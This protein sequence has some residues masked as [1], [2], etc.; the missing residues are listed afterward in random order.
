M[1]R[2]VAVLLAVLSAVVAPQVLAD[3]DLPSVTEGSLLYRSAVSGRYEP[4]PLQ[5]TD[6]SIDVR[7]L[8]ASATVSQVYV[9]RTDTP[10]E[11]VYVFPLPHEAAVYE[12]EMR[13]GD[14]LI[15]SVVKEREQARQTY[16][17]ARS[18]GK[19]AALVEQERPNVFTTSLANLMPGDRVEVRL[20]YVEPLAWQDGRVRLV[21]PMVVGPRYIPGQALDRPDTG[22]GWAP[23]TTQVADASRITPPLRNP[24]G[25]LG[26]ES[27]SDGSPQGARDGIHSRRATPEV[28]PGHDIA[29]RVRA[30]LGAPLAAVTSP[31]HEIEWTAEQGA[32]VVTLAR[33][34]TLPN[35]DFVLELKRE[36][37]S[38]PQ[39]ALFL[40]PDARG[41]ETHFMLV[42]YPPSPESLA[43]RPPLELVFLI[44]V[45][46]S[47][48]GT[49]IEQ[50]RAALLQGLDRLRPDDHFNIVAYDHQYRWFAPAA[51]QA[52]AEGLEQGRQFVRGLQAEG[53]TELLPALRHV[54]DT[55]V[56]PGLTRYIV[57]L[58][59]GCLGNEDE[60]FGALERGLRQSRL[61]TVAIG[62]APNHLLATRMARYGRGSFTHIADVGEVQAQMGRL[63]D[64]IDSPVLTG[65]ALSWDGATAEQVFPERLPDLFLRQP[66]VV[67][68]RL[69]GFARGRLRLSA[70]GAGA[71]FEQEIPFAA[72]TAQFH[73]GITTLWA[74]Q[75]VDERMDAWR[76]AEEGD[77]REKV[78]LA[79]VEHA[80]RYHLVTRFT[81]LVAVEEMV[82][83]PDGSLRQARVPTELPAG[84]KM[85][86]VV[87]DNPAGGTA[88]LFLEAL[89][90]ALLCAG[91]ALMAAM[92][93]RER[94]TARAVARS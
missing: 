24:D 39:T 26:A 91:L 79:L 60:V 56:T 19:R 61:F 36:E 66:L 1:L 48:Q 64:Q 65:L 77:E 23:D 41:G 13:V 27:R 70:Q 51:V 4:V 6:V 11:A 58:T 30:D 12:M 54:L 21:F 16:Q 33:H 93:A 90:A 5:H 34:A 28:R 78:R 69:P 32:A 9:N 14:R 38:L 63:L 85:E 43:Q 68:G 45:S 15:R 37:T 18:E 44:D 89:G 74:R 76:R 10:V 53:G 40:S 29:L 47:M 22:T 84:W 50:A 87:G 71:P 88:D 81:S 57:L 75:L 92:R 35:R 55:P 3:S 86:A 52:G 31:S 83:N 80:V 8:V 17:A 72:E 59:D 42:A 2:R 94:R 67:Y 49:S 82:A 73:P 25:G 46:G 62:S 7:G 20:S